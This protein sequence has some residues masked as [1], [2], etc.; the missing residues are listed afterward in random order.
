MRI[1]ELSVP[2]YERVA[3]A[4]DPESGLRAIIAVHDRTLG[5]AL[6]GMRMW[7]YAKEEDAVFDVLRLSRGMTY[8]S[9]V[10]RTGL[11][12]GKSVMIG[13]SKKDKCEKLFRAMGRFIEAFGGAYITAEDVGTTVPDLV[14]VRQETRWVSG[15]PREMG[16]SGNPSPYT[17]R[18]VYLGMR[19]VFEERFGVS[20][21]KG[22]HVAI[23]GIGSVGTSLAQLL[24]Q[25]GAKL[26]LA[27]VN[28][29]RAQALAKEL[30]ASVCSADVVM[31]VECDVLSPCALGAGIN[32][33]TIPALRCKAI[34]GAAN[35]QLLE[36]R[37]GDA[38]RAKNIL[39][40]PDYVIN[41][42]G[43]INV[44]CEFLPGG[45][46]EEESLKRIDRIYENLKEVFA[47][48]KRDGVGTHVAAD[49]RAEEI[50]DETRRAKRK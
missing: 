39:Y 30:G 20:S 22:L 14:T 16:S 38:L 6:G 36:P 40:A 15:L 28:E 17:A 25:A 23:Q 26:T 42:G 49:R 48:S 50:L 10:G 27:D 32:D 43:I 45:Y 47:V 2:G 19:A 34:A 46:K 21:A 1:T 7:P 37:H 41:A 12:G 35:N 18:G 24:A 3:K 4:E 31:G 5:P 33:S 29:A 9:A 8:K 13:D 44:G 11:G